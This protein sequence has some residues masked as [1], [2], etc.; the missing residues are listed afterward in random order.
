M[1]KPP[2]KSLDIR[3][4]GKTFVL[5]GGRSVVAVRDF[6]LRIEPGEFVVAEFRQ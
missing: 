1:Q 5:S 4:L 6:S 3:G 2:A